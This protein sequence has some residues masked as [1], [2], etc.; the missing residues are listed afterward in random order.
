MADNEYQFKS[1]AS[2]NTT[3]RINTSGRSPRQQDWLGSIRVKNI[4][5]AASGGVSGTLQIPAFGTQFY[6]RVCTGTLH[7]KTKSTAFSPYDQGEGQNFAFDNAFDL[8]EL[9]NDNAFPVV[10]ELCISF[11][12]FID[13]KLI[14]SSNTNFQ[15]AY[16][17]YKTPSSAAVVNI[18]DLSGT[19]IAD[20]NGNLW[21]TISR[22]AI[23]VFN[24][25]TGV[26]LLLQ[27]KGSVVAND[28]AVGIIYPVTSIRFDF[29]GDYCLNVGGGNINAIVSEIYTGIPATIV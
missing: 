12:G 20:V 25:D 19:K 1:P 18:N 27:K 23:L 17:T 11:A 24:N 8:I 26:T 16:P 9:R 29:G 10:F 6:F 13:N 28:F 14:I 22:V 15:F 2:V 21:Y 7:A 5:A 4:V 3:N